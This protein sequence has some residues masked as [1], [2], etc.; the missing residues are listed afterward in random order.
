MSGYTDDAVIARGVFAN[1]IVFLQKPIASADLA[2]SVRAILDAG[3][4]G[5]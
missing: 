1:E 2:Q 3:N 5:F 4:P